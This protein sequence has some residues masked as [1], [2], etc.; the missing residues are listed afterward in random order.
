[1]A[2]TTNYPPDGWVDE[3]TETTPINAAALN[4][5]EAGLTAAAAT[6]D[7]ASA[8]V[9][10]KVARGGDTMT[11]HLAPAVVALTDAA[12][13]TLNASA[14]NDFR[15]TLAGSRTMA[16][17]ANLADGQTFTITITQDATGGRLITWDAAYKFGAAGAPTLTATANGSDVLAFKVFGSSVRYLG[18][19]LG[20]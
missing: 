7:S 3:P 18:G 17:P 20:F 13:I 11:G 8:A 5:I 2:Y 16:A 6:A 4:H 12:T 19:S 14:G 9:A 15:V 1:M 10:A